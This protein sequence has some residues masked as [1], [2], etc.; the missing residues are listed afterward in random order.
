MVIT[1]ALSI[2][3]TAVSLVPKNSAFAII[4]IVAGMV[5]VAAWVSLFSVLA[6]RVLE[7]APSFTGTSLLVAK[8]HDD[9]F[10]AWAPRLF[11]ND[12][13]TEYVR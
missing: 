3:A 11:E 1:I 10:K 4:G 2:P 8:E 6:S 5:M 13:K 12:Y 9:Y 7:S